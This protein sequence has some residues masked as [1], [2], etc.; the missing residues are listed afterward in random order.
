MSALHV[1]VD[2]TDGEDYAPVVRGH[3]QP[4][5]DLDK[6]ERWCEERLFTDPRTLAVRE[7]TG[8]ELLPF[9]PQA[10]VKAT[11]WGLTVEQVKQYLCRDDDEPP[12]FCGSY[13]CSAECD[14]TG[15]CDDSCNKECECPVPPAKD[16]SE[17]DIARVN[18]GGMLSW[19]VG[20]LSYGPSNPHKNL[21]VAMRDEI[22]RGMKEQGLL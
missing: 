14:A 3:G 2:V 21:A 19:M 18:Y 22:L 1:I 16:T 5:W 11:H 12:C 15:E 8:D 4:P 6:L 20:A 17:A 9:Y 13:S 10:L 7:I